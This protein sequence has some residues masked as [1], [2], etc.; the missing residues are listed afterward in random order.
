MG[1]TIPNVLVNQNPPGS[2]TCLHLGYENL[3][4]CPYCEHPAIIFAIV[5]ARIQRL[6]RAQEIRTKVLSQRTLF[7]EIQGQ[8]G[9][10]FVQ[11]GEASE[12]GRGLGSKLS[13]LECASRKIP[14]P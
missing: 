13:L 9:G 4:L 12:A 14:K 8:G 3:S 11:E 1:G 6:P 10:A 5:P 7:L 2:A